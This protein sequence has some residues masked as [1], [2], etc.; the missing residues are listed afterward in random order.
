M[1]NKPKS[2][3]TFIG[4]EEFLN[5][6]EGFGYNEPVAI[7]FRRYES[8]EREYVFNEI[9][10][11]MEK[12]INE[13]FT[14]NLKKSKRIL[15]IGSTGGGKTVL[16]ST[17]IDR[18]VKAGGAAAIFDLKG[19]YIKKGLSLQE[20][21]AKSTYYDNYWKMDLPRFILPNE[22]PQG[23]PLKVYYPAFL[24]KLT[25]RKIEPEETLSQFNLSSIN[26]YDLFTLFE[27]ITDN[28]SRFFDTLEVLWGIIE[29]HSLSSFDEIYSYF[30]NE[31]KDL[32]ERQKK[33][34]VR[35]LKILEDNLIMGD[36]YEPP[37]MIDDINDGFISILNCQGMTNL[38]GSN[39]PVSV[40][41]GILLRKIYNAKVKGEIDKDLHILITIDEIN[42]YVPNIGSPSSKQEFLKLLDLSRSEQI[43]LMYSTQDFRRCPPT[44][45][46]Q[47]DYI[48]VSYRI[49]LDDLADL[50]RQVLPGEYDC[51]Q[52]FKSKVGE[53]ISRLSKYKD[54]RR[55]WLVLDTNAKTMSYVINC[56]P[57]SHVV[58]E[59]E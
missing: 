6:Q 43:S 55:D 5:L 19:E 35:N 34:I 33:I 47:A 44:L 23:F 26:K 39:S 28:N 22:K 16:A 53:I 12:D 54:G 51:P 1:S 25:G 8:K 40:Y 7:D 21:F 3:L 37:S 57:L 4:E 14:I 38:S 56:M 48:F 50:I 58:T 59:G 31:D 52:T 29:D 42:K 10:I 49:T 41:V 30:E 13:E 46:S 20:K 36:Q 11:G 24:Q 18:F 2:F 27:N 15:I 17:I 45:L 32:D 9:S